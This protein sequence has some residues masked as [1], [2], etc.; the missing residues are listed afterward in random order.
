M[1]ISNYKKPFS[2]FIKKQSKP[3]QAVIEDEVLFICDNPET[4]ELKKGDLSGVRVHKFK[5][6]R[7]EYLIAYRYSPENDA[8]IQ[9]L[10]IDFY[11][12]GTHENFYADLKKYL[13]SS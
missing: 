13:K 4:G 11:Q 2:K 8:V 6:H 3:F 5:F 7:Q 1:Y 10:L 12:I 9:I